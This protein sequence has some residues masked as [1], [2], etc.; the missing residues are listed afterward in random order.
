MES[1]VRRGFFA[2]D[3]GRCG[4]RHTG[5]CCKGGVG[6]RW[7]RVRGGLDVTVYPN[8]F[9]ETLYVDMPDGVSHI[10]N[11]YGL[12]GSLV[13]TGR[14]VRGGKVAIQPDLS[15]GVYILHVIREDDGI[16][17]SVKILRR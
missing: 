11:V 4:I 1:V 13:W 10:V 15:S 3:T 2:V 16:V 9:A 8:P 17:K 14:Y 12:T 6:Y 5:V 7:R